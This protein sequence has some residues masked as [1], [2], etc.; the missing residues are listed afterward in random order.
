MT[1][2]KEPAF[3]AEFKRPIGPKHKVV[4]WLPLTLVLCLCAI[5]IVVYVVS[6]Q[7]WLLAIMLF[8]SLVPGLMIRVAAE[9][10][11]AVV[12]R[13][14]KYRGLRGPGH[15][16]VIPVI[17]TVAYWIDQRVVATPFVAEQTLTKDTVPVNVDAILFWMV[18]DPEKAAL[19]VENY[20]EAVA[21]VAQTAL[22][23]VVGRSM[24]ADILSGREALDKVLQEII[25]RRTEPWGITVQSVEIRDVI[26]PEE[27]QD[28]M[29]KEAQAE[30][31]RRARI[32]LGTAETE[33]AHRFAA[34]ADVYENNPIALQLRAMNILYEGLKEKGG[35]VVT[36][37]G[38]ADALNLG[39]LLAVSKSAAGAAKTEDGSNTS[40]EP[41]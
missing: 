36:P 40:S 8:L 35:L 16:W 39:S 15:F 28:A 10:E 3:E 14:G 9:W 11:K 2:K 20:Q 24:L 1:E 25:D 30:R 21:W 17:D 18:W 6:G 22:R 5:S 12:L 13:L 31:E 29:S 33:I 34:A 38:V 41:S 23:D 32:I 37:S 19:E 27:L 26:I 7:L 4:C